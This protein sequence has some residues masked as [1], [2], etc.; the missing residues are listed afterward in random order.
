MQRHFPKSL[1]LPA[2]EGDDRVWWQAKA[3]LARVMPSPSCFLPSCAYGWRHYYP[4]DLSQQS[5]TFAHKP[6]KTILAWKVHL[7][8]MCMALLHRQPDNHRILVV[9][10]LTILYLYQSCFRKF[11]NTSVFTEVILCM[12]VE[13]KPQHVV[14]LVNLPSEMIN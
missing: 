10:F 3:R 11:W 5:I 4:L 6:R 12:C 8:E 9:W 14:W 7:L 2:G 13:L 1:L